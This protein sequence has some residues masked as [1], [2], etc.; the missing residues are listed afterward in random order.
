MQC[1]GS[2]YGWPSWPGVIHTGMV[3]FHC[4][5]LLKARANSTDQRRLAI[6]LA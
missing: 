3:S 6:S 2:T 1:C 4:G 5:R